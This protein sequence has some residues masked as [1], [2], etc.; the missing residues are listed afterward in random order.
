MSYILDALEKAESERERGA[1]TSMLSQPATQTTG[2][3]GTNASRNVL[4]R[5]AITLGFVLVG[6]LVWR[7]FA[8]HPAPVNTSGVA[9][10]SQAVNQMANGATRAASAA[11]AEV[12]PATEPAMNLQAETA[13]IGQPN[14]A[15]VVPAKPVTSAGPAEKRRPATIAA[16]PVNPP[17]F[18]SRTGPTTTNSTNIVPINDLPADVR[19]TLPKTVISG[20]TYSDNPAQRLVIINGDVFREGDNPSPDLLLEKIR[21]K[22]VVL[23]FKGSRYSVAF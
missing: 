20:S 9:P 4:L 23:N 15:S 8:T 7:F 12:A 17:S 6:A 21:A 10:L 13:P 11:A 18:V 14:K 16:T 22:S 5:G 19:Q 3:G 1:V 2:A